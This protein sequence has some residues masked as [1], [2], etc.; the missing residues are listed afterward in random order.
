MNAMLYAS[1]CCSDWQQQLSI[2]VS[3]PPGPQQQTR[4]SGMQQSTDG[5][6]RQTDTVQVTT[7]DFVLIGPSNLLPPEWLCGHSK[8]KLDVGSKPTGECP[9]PHTCTHAQMDTQVKNI[10][11]L[12]KNS[13]SG[14]TQ[15]GWQRFKN[16]LWLCLRN[17][18]AKYGKWKGSENIEPHLLSV[19]AKLGFFH[20]YSDATKNKIKTPKKTLKHWICPEKDH[21][22]TDPRTNKKQNFA[23]KYKSFISYGSNKCWIKTGILYHYKQ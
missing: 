18:F 14:G 19:F 17:H 2:D 1:C 20:T 9:C 23:V 4:R 15:D 22:L 10:M 3:C 5:T 21:P 7:E 6:D 13:I 12:A 16:W 8:C 11:P